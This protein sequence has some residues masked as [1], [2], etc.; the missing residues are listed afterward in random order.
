MNMKPI[1]ADDLHEE[2]KGEARSMEG[3]DCGCSNTG[4]FIRR[5]RRRSQAPKVRARSG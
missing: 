5:S 3:N 2:N 1:R 4:R